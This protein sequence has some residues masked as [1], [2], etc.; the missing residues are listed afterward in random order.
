MK[1]SQ[2]QINASL[3]DLTE[4][5]LQTLGLP[6]E[7]FKE[8]LKSL[9]PMENMIRTAILFEFTEG[10]TVNVADLIPMVKQL[11]VDL[12][13]ILSRFSELDLIHWDKKSGNVTVAYPYSGI[14]TPHRVTLSGKSPAYSMCAIDALGIPSMFESDALIESECAHCGEKININVK[15]NV[16]VSN[17][18][19][20][21]V[22]VGTVTDMTSCSTTSCSTD[23][24]PPV[25]TS[26][27]PAIQFYCSDKHW[28]ES[29]EK[30]PTK[31]GT[32]LTL[33]EAF[34]V[35]AGVFGG[36]LQGFKN[37]MTI[38]TE[39]DKIILESE[40]FTCK[41]CLERVNEAIANLPE[42]TGQPESAG[43]LL[44]VPININHDTDIRNIANAAQTA[45][46]S[47]PYYPFPVTVIYR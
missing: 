28:S 17:P 4:K 45:L 41:G 37:E 46:E 25:S 47:D 21:V 33:L 6:E 12:Q 31:A 39:A 5:V 18:E 43:N 44:I 14:P 30:N 24:N 40:R 2:N 1:Q 22:G 23:P 8:K 34:E 35:G 15:N 13:S 32:R 20:V 26:C 42:V 10:K 3:Q 9:T 29:N 19:T 27:C 36:A 7:G 38:Q 16:P 11:G